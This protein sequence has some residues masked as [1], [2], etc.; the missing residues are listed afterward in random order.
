MQLIRQFHC[1]FNGELLCSI[2][3]DITV[4]GEKVH[5][6]SINADARISNLHQWLERFPFEIKARRGF[7]DMRAVFE[8]CMITPGLMLWQDRNT[9][10]DVPLWFMFLSSEDAK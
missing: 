2:F 3:Y 10:G 4:S 7:K 5:G 6:M 1:P 8:R 9:A